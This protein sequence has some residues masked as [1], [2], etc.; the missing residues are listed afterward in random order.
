MSLPKGIQTPSKYHANRADQRARKAFK[1]WFGVT[2]GITFGVTF[3]GRVKTKCNVWGYVWGYKNA[4]KYPRF[5]GTNFRFT[6]GLY[7]FL[8]G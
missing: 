4:K 8:A 6:P 2:L 3:L 1:F 5:E 7:P